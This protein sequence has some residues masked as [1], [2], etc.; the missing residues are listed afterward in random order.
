MNK[1][2]FL[3]LLM[4]FINNGLYG[5][6]DVVQP[7]NFIV[8]N[9]SYRYVLED[10][11]GPVLTKFFQELDEGHPRMADDFGDG[12]GFVNIPIEGRLEDFRLF[13]DE[14]NQAIVVRNILTNE[15]VAFRAD[16]GEIVE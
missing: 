9:I 15:S 6:S 1:I 14:A 16:D 8:R 2:K 11:N 4:L 5:I 10:M 3:I 7:V 13:I 12:A